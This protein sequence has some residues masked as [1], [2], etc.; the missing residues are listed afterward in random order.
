MGINENL[1]TTRTIVRNYSRPFPPGV[2]GELIH[3]AGTGLTYRWSQNDGAWIAYGT[4]EQDVTLYVD[5]VNGDDDA[6]GDVANP[7]ETIME[8]IRRLPPEIRHDVVINLLDDSGAPYTYEEAISIQNLTIYAPAS[9]VIQGNSEA[10]VLATGPNTVAAD[11]AN[12][13][14]WHS[15]TVVPD[16]GWTA[17]DLRGRLVSFSAGPHMGTVCAIVDNTTDTLTFGARATG[18]LGQYGPNDEFEILD[19]TTLIQNTVP[20]GIPTLSVHAVESTDNYPGTSTEFSQL[21]IQQ[22]RILGEIANLWALN[23][24]GPINLKLLNCTVEGLITSP[25]HCGGSLVLEGS[26]LYSASR[27]LDTV[28]NDLYIHFYQTGLYGSIL[29]CGLGSGGTHALLENSVFVYDPISSDNAVITL[30]SV[31]VRMASNYVLGGADGQARVVP[32]SIRSKSQMVL[33]MPYGNEIEKSF[34][35]GIDGNINEYIP[36]SGTATV[37]LGDYDSLPAGEFQNDFR[38]NSEYGLNLKGQY[39]LIVHTVQTSTVQNGIG[40]LRLCWGGYYEFVGVLGSEPT[41]DGADGKI[42]FDDRDPI[43]WQLWTDDA[44][45]LET[46]SQMRQNY[47]LPH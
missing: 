45:G 1:G 38:G 18:L 16:P 33:D 8:A 12:T 39:R 26:G 10:A 21:E 41:M 44:T 20:V 14:D 9:V 19:I 25:G 43:L 37:I 17:G 4:T 35:S 11:P 6:A 31:S 15:L 42:D 2:I 27:L 34:Y 36:G 40:G 3:D 22:V 47:S 30:D 28:L 46:L 24:A 23:I 29:L 7:L 13:G 5:G 32:I